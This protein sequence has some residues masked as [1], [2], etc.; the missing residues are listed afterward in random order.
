MKVK[1]LTACLG[2]MLFA[3]PAANAALNIFACE[4]EWA[5]LAQEIG[6]DEVKVTS[7][8]Q[9]KQDPHYI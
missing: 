5:A 9:A 7:A 8:T 1:N 6:G 3:S 4:P 2:L